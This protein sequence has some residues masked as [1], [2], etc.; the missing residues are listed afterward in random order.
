MAFLGRR[1]GCSDLFG[2]AGAARDFVGGAA[3]ALSL[4]RLRIHAVAEVSWP[5]YGLWRSLVSALVWG[6]RG[7]EFKSRRSD[8]FP[9]RRLLICLPQVHETYDDTVRRSVRCLLV[10]AS[11]ILL[12]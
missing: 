4:Q 8:H 2:M 5:R 7:R 9:F 6:T 12:V 3:T 1:R 10:S 11:E